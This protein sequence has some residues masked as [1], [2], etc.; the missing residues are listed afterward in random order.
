MPDQQFK[1]ESP[2]ERASPKN[3]STA[4]SRVIFGF[5]STAFSLNTS[6]V[7]EIIHPLPIT[8]LPN[9]PG[10]IEG[11]AVLRGELIAVLNIRSIMNLSGS[12]ATQPCKWI[13]LSAAAGSTKF[14]FPVNK[15]VEIT[16]QED[17]QKSEGSDEKRPRLSRT[18]AEPPLLDINFV[19]SKIEL[20]LH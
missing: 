15:M 13:V 8:P 4:E 19:I 10:S 9:C 14:A 3:G 20:A 6:S 12:Q 16:A 5:G 11:V 17:S 18:K 1:D 2:A 7:S